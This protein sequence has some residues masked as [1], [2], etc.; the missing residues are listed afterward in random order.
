MIM[1]S[2]LGLLII[3]RDLGRLLSCTGYVRLRRSERAHGRNGT[4]GE[5]SVKLLTCKLSCAGKGQMWSP[6]D[7][8]QIPEYYRQWAATIGRLGHDEQLR[9]L[10]QMSEE[11]RLIVQRLM[12]AA[13]VQGSGGSRRDNV[14]PEVLL[15]IVLGAPASTSAWGHA[16]FVGVQPK[17]LQDG[18]FPPKVLSTCS[19]AI[20]AGGGSAQT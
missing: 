18:N 20:Y 11:D 12:D 16:Y 9:T 14:R 8:D 2:W 4:Q 15:L 10:M 19:C 3:K 6:S 1:K 13:S 7:D 5:G 17:H